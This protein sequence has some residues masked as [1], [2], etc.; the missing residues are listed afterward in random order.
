MPHVTLNLTEYSQREL[1]RIAEENGILSRGAA[2]AWL[3]DRYSDINAPIRNRGRAGAILHPDL[4]SG[5]VALDN[6]PMPHELMAKVYDAM[7]GEYGAHALAA[8]S[9]ARFVM[10]QGA[11]S[12][13]DAEHAIACLLATGA[14]ERTVGKKSNRGK[15]PVYRKVPATERA[16]TAAGDLF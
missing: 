6:R 13:E 8:D 2:V 12:R 16:A 4:R 14:I 9:F 7:D 11:Q 3:I 5:P 10:S 1:A 15:R